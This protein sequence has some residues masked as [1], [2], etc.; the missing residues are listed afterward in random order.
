MPNATELMKLDGTLVKSDG[1]EKKTGFFDFLEIPAGDYTDIYFTKAEAEHIQARMRSLSTGSTAAIPLICTG[2]KCPFSA[3]CIFL[4]LDEERRKE[5]PGAKLMTPLGRSCLLEVNLV[6]QWTRMY[7]TQFEVTEEDVVDFFYCR[8]LAEID[9]MN[10]RLNN[11]LAKPENAELVMDV[12]VG[13]DK[14]GNPLTRQE[15][16]AFFEAKEKLAA[17]RSR[18]I[19]FMAGDRQEKWKKQSALKQADDGDLSSVGARL[20]TALRIEMGK[21]PQTINSEVLTPDDIIAGK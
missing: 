11:N 15:T 1:T 6:T 12:N 16:S 7:L 8:E 9:L 17:R 19:K 14:K 10:W 4:R 2:K 20:A 3:Q 21:I 13:V 5:D 18:I